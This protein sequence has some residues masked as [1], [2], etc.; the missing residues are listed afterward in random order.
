LDQ[1]LSKSDSCPQELVGGEA[2]PVEAGFWSSILAS[3]FASPRQNR[4]T[5][6]APSY[7]QTTQL[8]ILLAHELAH[9]ILSHHL[10]TLSSGEVVV[11][12][13]VSFAA[14]LVRTLLF[15]VTMVFGPFVNDAVA[16]IGLV[17]QGNV[18]K[19]TE[20]CTSVKQEFEADVVST[21]FV[22]SILVIPRS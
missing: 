8:A 3:I 13:T 7:E 17:S 14:D 20:Y 18:R 9:L 21:R 4:P 6:P 5:A 10:E 2:P 1:I 12:G 16:N 22:Q 15:P 11:P 19:L